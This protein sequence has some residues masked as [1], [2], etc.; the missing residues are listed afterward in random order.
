MF[1]QRSMGCLHSHQYLSRRTRPWIQQRMRSYTLY[2][3]V[4]TLPRLY[5]CCFHRDFW[6][7]LAY[8]KG[9]I[10]ENNWHPHA[11][12]KINIATFQKICGRRYLLLRATLTNCIQNVL[13]IFKSKTWNKVVTNRKTFT[14][15]KY[16]YLLN[17]Y[18]PWKAIGIWP[19][20]NLTYIVSDVD[21]TLSTPWVAEHIFAL[22]GALWS[23]PSCT[24]I[25]APMT[26]QTLCLK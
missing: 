16:M 11:C 6:E 3:R 2:P 23:A 21:L 18:T 19:V 12:L 20:R 14:I 24:V 10:K 17:S 26:S 4:D 25:P 7:D 13:L 9:K 22:I 1:P 5:T 15:S 8:L